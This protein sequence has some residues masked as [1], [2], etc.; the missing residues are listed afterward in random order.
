MAPSPSRPDR[1]L[2]RLYA[3]LDV[4]LIQARGLAPDSVLDAWLEAGVR[5]LQLRAKSL[6]F[7][8]MLELAQ[9]SG[10]VCRRAGA[11][12]IVNDRADVAR[13]ARSSG[14]H[15][16]Q[17]DLGVSEARRLLSD[18]QLVGVSAHHPG[19]VGAALAQSADYVAIGPVYQTSTK[20]RTDPTVGLDGVVAASALTRA[21]S[22]P[23]VAIGGITLESAPAVLASGADA[24][25]VISD[26][27]AG[28]WRHRVAEFLRALR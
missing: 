4:D 19:Q 20:E 24:V 17:D 14:V 27:M 22:T 16:G 18:D 3:I 25:A 11:T 12:F 1:Q 9:R 23:L 28:D 8:P 5:L 7:G 10:E 15:L 2:P 6:T 26:L 13:L 21:V